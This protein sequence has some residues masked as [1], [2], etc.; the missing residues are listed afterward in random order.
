MAAG[1]RN[2]A[3]ASHV[4]LPSH[5][6]NVSRQAAFRGGGALRT[7]HICL[8]HLVTLKPCN[9]TEAP[10]K[11]SHV[12]SLHVRVSVSSASLQVPGSKA[13][14]WA[15]VPPVLRTSSGKHP[16]K[17]RGAPQYSHGS[18]LTRQTCS[19]SSTF[20]ESLQQR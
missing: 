15:L 8:S 11:C 5:D 13:F 6:P 10:R 19:G 18:L 14:V 7:P 12:C 20:T 3:H 1:K 9:D 17:E 4:T 16:L 2:I